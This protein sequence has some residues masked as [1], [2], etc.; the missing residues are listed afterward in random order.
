MSLA[1]HFKQSQC[2]GRRHFEVRFV[3]WVSSLGRRDTREEALWG[4]V[5]LNVPFAYNYGVLLLEFLVQCFICVVET[6]K[7]GLSIRLIGRNMQFAVWEL[8]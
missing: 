5:G 1:C 8:S 3:L 7:E 6:A 2:L 4:L